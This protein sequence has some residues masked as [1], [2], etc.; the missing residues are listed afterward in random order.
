MLRRII[1]VLVLCL[2]LSAAATA[3]Q[4]RKNQAKNLGS[5][6]TAKIDKYVKSLLAEVDKRTEP[7]LVTA[8]TADP[9]SDK[10][11][12]K[13]FAS[14]DALD[15]AREESETYT[16]AYSWKMDGKIAVSNFTYFSES[17]D[18]AQYVYHF[19]RPDGTLARVDGE[20]RTFM[21]DCIIRQSFYFK[22][23]GRRI[24]KTLAYFDL[25]TDKVRKPCL[26]ADALKFDH[27]AAV[28]KLPFKER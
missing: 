6:T 15:K 26:G 3:Q 22:P 17:G 18:W 14:T 20:L 24:K 27:F 2:S 9:E 10:P 16:I 1:F 28:D 12:W 8:D 4:H 13:R 21:D 7:D 23:D 11:D 25:I 19:F 5:T